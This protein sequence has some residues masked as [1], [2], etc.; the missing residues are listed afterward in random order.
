[1]APGLF[2]STTPPR[3][4]LRKLIAPDD[5]RLDDD[6]R[7][8][9]F[10]GSVAVSGNLALIGA[11]GAD[12]T[13]VADTG[14]AYVFNLLTGALVL[15]LTAA[16]G[17]SGDNFGDAVA[18]NGNIALI[19]APF[20]DTPGATN[21]GAAYLFDVTTG[22]Q[23]QK[24]L[25]PAA[26]AGTSRFFGTSVALSGKQAL[27]SAAGLTGNAPLQIGAV[28]VFEISAGTVTFLRKLVAADG[29]PDEDF[30]KSVA[31]SGEFAL[32]GAPRDSDLQRELGAAY[33]FNIR[34]GVQRAKLTHPSLTAGAHFGAS[35]ALDGNLALVGAPENG[36]NGAASGH[37]YLFDAESGDVLDVIE[38]PD[39]HENQRFGGSTGVGS[40]MVVIGARN[41]QDLGFLAGAAYLLQPVAMP[42]DF[43]RV[44][45]IKDFAP[46]VPAAN[47]LSFGDVF[48]ND[49]SDVIFRAAL[50]GAGAADGRN[51]GVWSSLA[52]E[53]SLDLLLRSGDGLGGGVR[54]VG[55]ANPIINK[56]N[57]AIF[58]AS[59]VGTGVSV[60]NN[61]ALF[62]DDGAA[63]SLLLQL[64]N[65]P[66]TPPDA[67]KVAQFL[68]VAQSRRSITGQVVAYRLAPGVG[69]VTAGSDTGI[70]VA[71]NTGS[72]SI[73]AS[74]GASSPIG[75]IVPVKYGQFSR[76]CFNE[77][78]VVFTAGLQD[79]P[80]ANQGLFRVE[81][82]LSPGGVNA[83]VVRKGE[84]AA[85]ARGGVFSAFL[86]E[87]ASNAEDVA[88]R[89]SVS[90]AGVTS[91]NNEGIWSTHTGPTTLV[92]REGDAVP[93]EFG[94][95][96]TVVW[97]RFIHF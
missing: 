3:A 66:V 73:V 33:L 54:V 26:D 18:L 23:L 47:F 49:S 5:N 68:Q 37:A 40:N 95:P 64:G 75:A 32:V 56:S 12:R 20:A 16:D 69:G 59:L 10:G 93:A 45:A 97:S 60:A 65:S 63:V 29:G 87:T 86:A 61:R 76:V 67:R 7:L 9:G 52:P 25:E 4:L 38:A 1:M 46:D 85:G 80:A 50:S 2:T 78:H 30:G 21:S 17:V 8:D 81:P 31:L 39:C 43:D 84:T 91:L 57:F 77:E 89:A 74:E 51:I 6:V 62:G 24:I 82:T 53:S 44:T 79:L 58:E 71:Q 19:G 90:G 83:S 28:Q 14:A 70:L 41:D 22:V 35:V 48:R 15:R 13:G 36:A 88:F 55:L 72:R 27:I 11:Q 94:L 42:L 92:A 96:S 34:T